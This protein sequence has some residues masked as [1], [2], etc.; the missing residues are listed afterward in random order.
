M[1]TGTYGLPAAH[2]RPRLNYEHR[3]GGMVR[4]PVVVRWRCWRPASPEPGAG[5]HPAGRLPDA[6]RVADHLLAGR[7]KDT[8]PLFAGLFC[9]AQMVYA[10]MTGERLLLQLA[11]PETPW[12]IYL[13]TEYLAWFASMALFR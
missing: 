12:E 9:L 1:L 8:A 3:A 13:R 2:R 10:D 6:G 5:H 4:A 7:R 11:G